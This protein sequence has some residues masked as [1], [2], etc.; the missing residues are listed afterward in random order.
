[1]RDEIQVARGEAGEMVHHIG[2]RSRE[3]DAR[4]LAD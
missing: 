4:H 3:R 2:V 1:M